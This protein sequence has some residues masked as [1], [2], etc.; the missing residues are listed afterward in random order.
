LDLVAGQVLEP[1]A[2]GIVEVER[3]VLYHDEIVGRSSGMARKSVVLE[4]YTGI[5]VP[6]VS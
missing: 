4:P 3:Q 2:C 6:V 1:R 5:G